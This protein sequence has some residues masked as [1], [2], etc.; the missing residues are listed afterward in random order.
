MYFYLKIGG[1]IDSSNTSPIFFS[2]LGNFLFLL[3]FWLNSVSF[4][5][6]SSQLILLAS[7]GFDIS[8]NEQVNHLVPF[9]IEW[10]LTSESH[11]FSGQHPENH[12]DG[13]WNS[14]VAWDDNIDEIQWGISV[15]KSNGWDVNVW[16]FND[17]LSVALWI[18][19]DQESWF[20]EFFGQLIGKSTWNPSWWWVSG[21]SGVLTEFID[22]SL[23]VLF[24]T[25]NDD[26]SEV[27]NWSDKSGGEF[28][29]SVGFINF[30]DI[31]SSLVL[32]L[33]ELFHVV[34]NL[35]G[36]EM[37]LNFIIDIR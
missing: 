13:L 22:S 14:V 26:F 19:N 23:T 35:V 29:F 21:T 31:I 36:S 1:N 20:L 24:S 25:D 33:D 37:D 2:S 4:L 8:G 34:I 9:L 18:S 7:D 32:F 6:L 17:G 30:E 16:S 3:V 12:S 15:A 11:D 5:L 27:R 10:N 28:D